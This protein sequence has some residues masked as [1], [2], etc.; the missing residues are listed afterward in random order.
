MYNYWFR[1][2]SFKL[3]FFSSVFLFYNFQSF[4]LVF[5]GY[6]YFI[7]LSRLTGIVGM[8]LFKR[9]LQ[10]SVL[11]IFALFFTRR[12]TVFERSDSWWPSNDKHGVLLFSV[13]LIKRYVDDAVYF[14]NVF[15]VYVVI[16]KDY[17]L[18]TDWCFHSNKDKWLS[19]NPVQIG[20]EIG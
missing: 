14:L 12:A 18:P 5:W 3:L 15:F 4:T 10:W 6:F 13:L 16:C 8:S 1:M 7:F 19:E 20:R 9:W 11:Y 17:F 2:V